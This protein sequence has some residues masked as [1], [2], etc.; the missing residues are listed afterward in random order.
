MR[1]NERVLARGFTLIELLVV[2]AIIGLLMSILLPSLAEAR[3]KGRITKC[4]A[5][6]KGLMN[7]THSYFIDSEDIF[8]FIAKSGGICSWF[9]GG[10]TSDNSW[11]TYAGGAFFF[12][13]QER[14]FN[15]AILGHD[16]ELD[17]WQGL[18]V[19]R[20]TELKMFQCPSDHLSNQHR[21][22]SSE[23]NPRNISSYDDVG[24]SYHFALEAILDTSLGEEYPNWIK[25]LEATQLRL[26]QEATSGFSGMFLVFWE[27]PMDWAL[28][29]SSQEIGCH[30]K[31]SRHCAAYLDG[32][33][34]YR[35]Y[36][37]RTHG[38][39]GWYSINPNWVKKPD[40][41]PEVWYEPVVG[42]WSV[43][44][45]EPPQ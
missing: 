29:D 31:F 1:R 32:H 5:N 13:A 39:P 9:Y 10:K 45:V 40:N 16:P 12:R 6:L 23:Q 30:G 7:T 21:F 43:K 28:Y 38:G 25:G 20:R 19:K 15:R 3:E 14:P 44:S 42:G 36:D 41:E 2:V 26:I 22:M 37:T 8:P 17:E 11:R 34:E 35:Y 4:L 27:D 18:L 33:A 24:T